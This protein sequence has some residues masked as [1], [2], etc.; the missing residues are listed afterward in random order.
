MEGDPGQAL[1]NFTSSALCWPSCIS[2]DAG[3]AIK[4]R[5]ATPALER[6]KWAR[7]AK[8]PSPPDQHLPQPVL[9]TRSENASLEERS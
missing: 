7:T 4:T 3:G 2:A 1:P 6:A 5:K 9:E 8:R